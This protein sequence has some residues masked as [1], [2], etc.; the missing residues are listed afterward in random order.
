MLEMSLKNG[1]VTSTGATLSADETGNLMYQN[2]EGFV[3][4]AHLDEVGNITFQGEEE[5]DKA[6]EELLTAMMQ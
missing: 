6:R 2:K 4:Y 1:I 3:A 5:S